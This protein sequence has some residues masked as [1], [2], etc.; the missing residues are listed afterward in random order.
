MFTKEIKYGKNIETK[1]FFV[2]KLD[3][4]GIS[5]KYLGYFLL[6][7]LMEILINQSRRVV[8][9]S[10]DVYPQIANK[11]GKTVCTIER[12]IRNLIDKCWN[13][14]MMEKLNVYYVEDEK[15]TCR[16]FVYLVKNYVEKS[17]I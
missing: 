9:F 4:L 3:E 1:I 14:E 17:I 7:E 15:P 16:E 5:K 10:R 6:V 13:I 2:K 11:F 8:S 12:N